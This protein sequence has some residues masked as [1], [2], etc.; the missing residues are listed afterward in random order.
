MERQSPPSP[1]L[2]IQSDYTSVREAVALTILYVVEI[3]ENFTYLHR[4]C[5]SKWLDDVEERF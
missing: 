4:T 3:G 1:Y 5:M 2:N